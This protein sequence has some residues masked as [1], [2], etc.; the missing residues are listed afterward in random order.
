MRHLVQCP[1]AV[2]CSTKAGDLVVL[3]GE[4]VVVGDFFVDG[5]GLLRVDHDLF[6]GLYGDNLGV[7]VWLERQEK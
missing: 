5:D 4:F 7:A 2:L 1:S 3:Q 6:L